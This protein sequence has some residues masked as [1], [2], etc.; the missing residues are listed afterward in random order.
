MIPVIFVQQQPAATAASARPNPDALRA[1]KLL[2]SVIDT[3]EAPAVTWNKAF[4]GKP[5]G[6]TVLALALAHLRKDNRHDDVIAGLEAA[7]R[8][9]H[10]QPW[11]YDV[12]AIEM[13]IAGRSQ[14]QI[15]RVLTSRIDFAPGN[16]AQMLVTASMLAGFDAFDRAIEICREAAKRTPWEPTVWSAA[17]KIADKSKD[18]QSIIWSR[19][20][21]IQHVWSGDYRTIHEICE[22][23]LEDLERDLISNGKPALASQ[24]RSAKQQAMQRDIRITIQWTGDADLDLS[25]TEPGGQRCSRKTPLTSNGGILIQQSDGGQERGPHTEEYICPIAKSGEYTVKVQHIHGRVIRGAVTI[26]Q[27]RYENAAHELK[28]QLIE[29][30]VVENNVTVKIEVNRGRAQQ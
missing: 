12:L 15:D 18:P 27:I 28:S 2:R 13:K 7:I 16:Q 5:I 23:E 6:S 1:E 19:A 25:V 17:R 11:M 9:D 24:L 30:G 22:I 20:G 8:N 26:K 3:E 4:Q 14:K 21:T 29:S 10:A